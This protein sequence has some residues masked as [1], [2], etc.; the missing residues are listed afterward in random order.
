MRCR[1]RMALISGAGSGTGQATTQMIGAEGGRVAG[2]DLDQ[3]V[4]QGLSQ[5]S[6]NADA[7]AKGGIIAF[8]RKLSLELGPYGI[9]CKAIVPSRTLRGRIQARWE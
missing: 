9:A 1:D 2:M 6:S 5:S 7:I 4:G 8:T 3:I